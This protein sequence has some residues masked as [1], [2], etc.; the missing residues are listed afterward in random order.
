M[1]VRTGCL[2]SHP[3]IH[4]GFGREWSEIAKNATLGWELAK[5]SI[6]CIKIANEMIKG[7]GDNN[8]V[9]L[10][11]GKPCNITWVNTIK[12]ILIPHNWKRFFFHNVFVITLSFQ[13]NLSVPILL[14]LFS[15]LVLECLTQPSKI[16]LIVYDRKN[17]CVSN[18]RWPIHMKEAGTLG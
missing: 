13:F 9:S 17:N 6:R 15:S 5:R 18:S 12:S 3:K 2:C 4:P 1:L 14:I 10:R 7:E 11:Q 16:K 8:I